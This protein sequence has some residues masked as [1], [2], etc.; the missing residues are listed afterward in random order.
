[1]AQLVEQV[2]RLMIHKLAINL[3]IYLSRHVWHGAEGL[4][5]LRTPDSK[6]TSHAR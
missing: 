6:V 5:G 2:V 4:G 3:D 1:M